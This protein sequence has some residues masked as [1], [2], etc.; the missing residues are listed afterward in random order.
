MPKALRAEHVFRVVNGTRNRQSRFACKGQEVAYILAD[1]K[2][3]VV[4]ENFTNLFL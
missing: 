3:T 1:V 4:T 2:E